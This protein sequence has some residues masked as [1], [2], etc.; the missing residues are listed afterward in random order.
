MAKTFREW[1]PEQMLLMPPAIQDWIRPGH[2]VHFIVAIVRGELD[3]RPILSGYQ[4]ERGYPPFHPMM[5][6]SV[7][8]YAYSQGIYSS[9]RIAGACRE[10]I[11]FM[12]LTGRQEPDFRTI[13]LFRLRHLES[14]KGLFS[15]VLKLCRKAGL[16]SLGHVA[17]DG[18]KMRANASKS[19]SMS[20][21]EMEKREK[22]LQASV[23]EWFDKAA[24]ADEEEDRFYGDREDEVPDWEKDNQKKLERIRQAKAELEAEAKAEAEAAPDPTRTRHEAKPTGIPKKTAQ[25][26]FTDPDSEIMKSKDGFMQAYNCQAAVDADNQ[27]IVAQHI[28][29][30]G[31]DTHEFVPLLKE[32]QLHNGQQAKE[33]SGDS[34]Y[35]CEHNLKQL[36]R[37]RIRGYVA[38]RWQKDSRGHESDRKPPARVGKYARQMW[39]RL[40]R[41]GHRSRYRLR[42]QVVEPV[43]GHIKQARGFRQFLLRGKNKVSAEW[44]LLCTVHNLLKLAAAAS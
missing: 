28:G 38:N 13:N 8:L 41:G 37:R 39:Q 29:E 9:R 26:N 34:A 22:Q 25:W 44:S 17:V 33:I 3:L 11:D 4:E 6:V 32:I 20:Y 31:S 2:L 1:A 5:M 7:L 24:Q 14:L 19:K 40:R 18:T 15:Q 30:N 23:A 27:I 21:G 35:S 42:K 10:R 16:V 12:V 36:R 43:F